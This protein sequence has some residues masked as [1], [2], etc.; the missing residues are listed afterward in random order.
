MANFAGKRHRWQGRIVRTEG[1]I[2]PRTRM[3]QAIA[4]VDDPYGRARP[5]RPPLAVGMFVE[6]EID[7]N[8]A[9]SVF[10]LPRIV[11]R[12]ADQVLVV[13]KE[14]RLRFRTV[15]ILRKESDQVIIRSGLE[16]GERVGISVVEA[17]VDGMKVRVLEETTA[18]KTG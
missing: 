4:Q 7:G 6:A 9:V 13:D 15:D 11:L 5:G 12:S 2:D 18:E 10:V 14:N 16:A 17:A 1:E 8:M 3:V